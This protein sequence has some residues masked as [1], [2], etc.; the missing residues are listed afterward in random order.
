MD[1]PIEKVGG[2]ALDVENNGSCFSK[3]IIDV[4]RIEHPIEQLSH[5]FFPMKGSARGFLHPH[6]DA[7]GTPARETAPSVVPITGNGIAFERVRRIQRGFRGT[8]GNPIKHCRSSS[9]VG[10]LNMYISVL[11]L[12]TLKMWCVN[13]SNCS[14]TDGLAENDGACTCGNVECTEDTG[15]ICFRSAG[16]DSCRKTGFGSYGY[17]RL[18]SGSTCGDSSGRAYIRSKVNC[19][20]AAESMGLISKGEKAKEVP[21]VPLEEG[22]NIDISGTGTPPAAP[23]RPPPSPAGCIWTNNEEFNLTF[24]PIPNYGEIDIGMSYIGRCDDLCGH[25]GFRNHC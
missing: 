6:S 1:V 17:S 16:G 3:V 12:L 23:S 20:A 25:Q 7:P 9:G 5:H 11:F 8:A 15:Y 21:F 22:L 2:S 4:I 10:L 19:E 14:V 24:T 13:G 18:S